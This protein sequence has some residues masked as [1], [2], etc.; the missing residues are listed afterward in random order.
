MSDFKC[1]KLSER[2]IFNKNNFKDY[3]SYE[4][5]LY[6]WYSKNILNH[7]HCFLGKKIHERQEGFENRKE[8]SF[9][10][11]IC[12]NSNGKF[13]RVLTDFNRS[14]R[15]KWSIELPKLLNCNENCTGCSGLK[16]WI[17]KYRKKNRH[18]MMFSELKYIVILDEEKDKFLLVT[19]YYLDKEH[20]R[21]SLKNEYN[22]Y[23]KKTKS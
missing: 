4:D 12:K 7:E 5:Y 2:I 20:R 1:K 13:D 22:D 8:K 23:L 10:H 18:M 11:L 17:K 3:F 19:A 21:I 14:S 15:I 9:Y 6:K 16:Y